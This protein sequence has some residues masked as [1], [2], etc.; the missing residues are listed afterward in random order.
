[1]LQKIGLELAGIQNNLDTFQAQ[2][3]RQQAEMKSLK[4]WFC[5]LFAKAI[6]FYHKLKPFLQS[7]K[8]GISMNLTWQ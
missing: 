5:I 3:L 8:V 4:V 2:I 6:N 7:W 1:M